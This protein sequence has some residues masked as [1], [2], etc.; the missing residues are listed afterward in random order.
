MIN[1]NNTYAI[2]NP[3]IFQDVANM[4]DI[5]R[6]QTAIEWK[7]ENFLRD[8]FSKREVIRY[9]GRI[10]AVADTFDAMTSDRPYQVAMKEEE[11]V[12]LIKTWSGT[13]FDPFVSEAFVRAF[14]KNKIKGIKTKERDEQDL[15]KLNARPHIA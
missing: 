12:D 13:R 15:V 9:G 7:A 5:L 4:V 10:L 3:N 8:T 1:S 2:L 6:F 14:Q 11:V